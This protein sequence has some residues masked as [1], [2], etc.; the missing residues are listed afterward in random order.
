MALFT[1]VAC[2]EPYTPP[3]SE[4]QQQYV[5]E[6]YIE[7]GEGSNPTF[8][9]ITRSLP[10]LEEIGPDQLA[11]LFVKDAKVSVNDGSKDV[12]LTQ[13]CVNELPEELRK[14]ALETLGLNPD[15]TV[16][17]ICIYADIFNTINKKQGGK[18]DLT[19]VVGAKTLTATTTIPVHV[20]IT[21]AE[22]RDPP[23]QPNDTLAT[24]WVKIN[25]PEEKNYF[26]YLTTT[27]STNQ[28]IP[29]FQSTSDDAFFNG[30]DFEFPLNKAE[31][32]GGGGDRDVD[33]FGLFERGDSVVVKW[34]NIDKAHYDFWQTRDFSANSG[35]P[36]ASYTRIKTNING[37]LGIWGGY[38]SNTL[39]LYCPP[40]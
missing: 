40:K 31:R 14:L 34:Y 22:F 5:V 11:K 37:G 17:D 29:P 8:V 32:R 9:I 13:L 30:K 38:S 21:N 27:D 24:L 12:S 28:L 15:S 39:R 7:E 36:F 33:A 19:V 1:F 6:G 4:E 23:G 10:Y 35:G 25:D 2:E 20:P 18:Y 26:R 16:L 3:T